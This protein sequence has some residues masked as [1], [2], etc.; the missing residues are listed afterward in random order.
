M[1]RV[2]AKRGKEQ[3]S[4]NGEAKGHRA[5]GTEAGKPVTQGQGGSTRTSEEE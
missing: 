4:A 5:G 2:R 1:A 3:D